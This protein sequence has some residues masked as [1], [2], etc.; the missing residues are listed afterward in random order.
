M[1]R[2][3]KEGEQPKGSAYYEDDLLGVKVGKGIAT[4]K[5]NELVK[6]ATEKASQYGDTATEATALLGEGVKRVA[7]YSM[8]E[9]TT[10]AITNVLPTGKAG[11][12]VKKMASSIGWKTSKAAPKVAEEVTETVSKPAVKKGMSEE[13]AQT[14]AAGQR[15][16]EPVRQT[17]T[18]KGFKAEQGVQ[19]VTPGAKEKQVFERYQPEESSAMKGAQQMRV[20][21]AKGI[22]AP[23]AKPSTEALAETKRLKELIPQAEQILRTGKKPDGTPLSKEKLDQLRAEVASWRETVSLKP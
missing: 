3:L 16:V 7:D 19:N 20:D 22:F 10:E 9:D 2:K 15:N 13:T 14:L 4:R 17:M 1:A 23:K 5:L 8:P 21:E 11:N 12:L 6:K 18:G